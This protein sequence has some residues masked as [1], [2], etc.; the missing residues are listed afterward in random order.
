MPRAWRIIKAK[1][2]ASAFTGEGARLFGSR[3]SSPGTRVAF[4]SETLSLATLEV[5][6][7]LQKSGSL[8][9][10]VV[11]T[12]DFPEELVQELDRSILPRNW[13]KSPV[14][15]QVQSIGDRW[16]KNVLSVMLR[17]PSTIITHE[18]NFL[19]N[20]AHDDF[21]K[22]IIGGPSPLDIDSRVIHGSR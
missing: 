9:G 20:P 16:V 2:A 3:W 21:P 4:A 15:P 8:A 13:R 19:I 10:Y 11:F 12:L 22:L 6:V 5:L 1:H 7:H 18:H 14:L 17:V